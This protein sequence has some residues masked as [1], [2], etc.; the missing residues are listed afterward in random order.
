MILFKIFHLKIS[1]FSNY[2]HRFSMHS[3]GQK[4]INNI[5]WSYNIGPVHFVAFS[6]ELHYFTHYGTAQIQTQFNWLK[7]DL[8]EAN[9]P[10]NRAKHPWIIT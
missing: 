6:T 3:Q 5:F 10:E 4:E 9:K 2:N 8:E 7:K 1:N